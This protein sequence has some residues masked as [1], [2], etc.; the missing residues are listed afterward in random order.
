M[1]RS[2]PDLIGRRDFIL[3]TATLAGVALPG[4]SWASSKPCPPPSVSV[5]GGTSAA[6]NCS[7]LAPGQLPALGLRGGGAGKPW[8]FGQVFRKGDAPEAVGASGAEAFQADVRNRWS[9]GSVKLAVVSGIGGTTIQFTRTSAGGAGVLTEKQLAAALPL[10][11]IQVGGHAVALNDLIGTDARHRTVFAGPVMANW[12]YRQ[13]LT[14]GTDL[15]LWVDV[16]Y[17]SN[18][19]VELFPWVENGFLQTASA[20]NFQATCVV[21]INGAE[22]F[23]QAIDFKHRTR[24]PLLKGSSAAH[25]ISQDPGITPVHDTAY[26]RAT[27]LIPNYGWNS[28][29]STRLDSLVQTYTPNTLAGA[30]AAMG[31]AGGEGNVNADPGV[32]YITSSGD[33]RAYRAAVTFGLS[34]GSWPIHFRDRNSL[35]PI[36][37]SDFPASGLPGGASGGTNGSPAISHLRGY[38]FI[39]YVLTGRWWF[40]DEIFYWC[41]YAY[42]EVPNSRFGAD[43]I[44]DP[45]SA[46]SARRAAWALNTLGHALLVVP[47]G[48]PLQ[49][50]LRASWE[51]NCAFYATRFVTG[52]TYRT[53]SYAQA[54]VHPQGMFG[55][56]TGSAPAT[57]PYGTPGGID[58][59]WDAA[60]MQNYLVC[61]W[62]VTSDYELPISAQARTNH[63]TV[64]DYGY[65]QVISRS[66]D[67]SAYNWRRFI[68]YSYPFGADS[69]GLP[70]ETWYTAAQSHKAYCE[71]LGFDQN[72]SAV[73]GSTLLYRSSSGPEVALQ[74]GVSVLPYGASA[75]MGLALAA[76]HGA[77]GAAN[78]WR[79]ISSASNFN[80]SFDMYF[81]NET[82]A[83]GVVPRNQ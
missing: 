7:T 20:T 31:G 52:G 5:A 13:A 42:L 63:E 82:P 67:G 29:S 34:S 24:I 60:F 23:N 41:G 39:P 83:F 8:T 43:G 33:E 75:T 51:A 77:A 18:G 66:G 25:W 76:E 47:N 10:V 17:Y 73:E 15:S 79:R 14:V 22:R 4:V 32:F 2:R 9:D 53:R 26:L 6:G 3:S 57:S 56:Y 37:F 48:H 69:S 1:K 12:I 49:S 21:K 72:L 68:M 62:G 50:D 36:K 70:C 16:R 71:A 74:Y 27:K 44:H 78:G 38:A 65:K 45:V 19:A 80:S 54:W 59:W 46:G 58:Q 35:E 28:P 61:V 40:A 11:T 55:A 81:N 30:G 64:R